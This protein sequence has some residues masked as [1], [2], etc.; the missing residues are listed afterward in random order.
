MVVEESEMKHHVRDASRRS[1]GT[2]L[3]GYLIHTIDK[4]VD[5]DVIHLEIAKQPDASRVGEDEEGEGITLTW[6]KTLMKGMVLELMSGRRKGEL[7][8]AI[9]HCGG[10]SSPSNG[11]ERELKFSASSKNLLKPNG[12]DTS[13]SSSADGA[14][15]G[16]NSAS[17]NA[18]TPSPHMMK[19]MAKELDHLLQHPPEGCH[20]EPVG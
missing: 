7:D 9:R 13:A 15:S 8:S 19:R 6:C 12:G 3:R 16:A 11:S 5:G 18:Y 14:R 1:H 20:V 17:G 2:N 4:L 10:G